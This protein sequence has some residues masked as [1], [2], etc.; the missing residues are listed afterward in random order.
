MIEICGDLVL[1]LPCVKQASY[2][3]GEVAPVPAL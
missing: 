2:L 3:E 1:D